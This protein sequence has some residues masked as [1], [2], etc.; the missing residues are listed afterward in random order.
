MWYNARVAAVQMS[1]RGSCSLRSR[2]MA[3]F[4]RRNFPL[5]DT[6][7]QVSWRYFTNFAICFITAM[8]L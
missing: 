8:Y 5:R 1:S 7:N 3:V 4:L 2:W 6:K